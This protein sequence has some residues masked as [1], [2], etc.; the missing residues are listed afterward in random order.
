MI[1]ILKI[2][3]FIIL[4]IASLVSL[5]LFSTYKVSADPANSTSGQTQVPLTPITTNTNSNGI[6][7]A[8]LKKWIEEIQT[9]VTA[10]LGALLVI[11]IIFAGI[12]YSSSAADPK[13][14]AQAVKRISVS[15][16]ILVIFIL[17]GAIMSWLS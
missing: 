5:M 13:K 11:N 15:L 1:K 9:T 17:S 6:N 16:G 4:S 3:A 2:Q 7:N 8:G 12:Q 10:I 14:K